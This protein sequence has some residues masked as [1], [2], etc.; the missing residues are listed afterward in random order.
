MA[1][2]IADRVSS[3]K[4]EVW[5]MAVTRDENTKVCISPQRCSDNVVEA[6]NLLCGK[7]SQVYQISSDDRFSAEFRVLEEDALNQKPTGI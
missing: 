7:T 5:L 3:V 4:W 6:C 1:I 2:C